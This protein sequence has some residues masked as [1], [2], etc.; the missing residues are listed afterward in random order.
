MLCDEI[1]LDNL[2][3]RVFHYSLK[4]PGANP[5][6]INQKRLFFQL[7]A[8]AMQPGLSVVLLQKQN[9]QIW[10]RGSIEIL[11]TLKLPTVQLGPVWNKRRRG[12]RGGVLLQIIPNPKKGRFSAKP[13]KNYFF[14][15][16]NFH[17]F[18]H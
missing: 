6:E 3:S 18:V 16:T 13:H 8:G 4:S 2:R 11:S 15:F 1:L 5:G 7:T 10:A 9:R 14:S 12:G 17:H